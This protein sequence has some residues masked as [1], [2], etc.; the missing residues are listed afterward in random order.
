MTAPEAATVPTGGASDPAVR[1]VLCRADVYWFGIEAGRVRGLSAA[2]AAV[3]SLG[4]LL[5][6][7]LSGP[8]PSAGRRL[9]VAAAQGE[10]AFA[11]AE[12]V[13]QVEVPATAIHPLPV[14]LAARQCLPW[15]RALALCPDHAAAPIVILDFTRAD[16][17]QV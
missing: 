7:P 5:G 15:V 12:P 13:I 16:G 10:L 1:L 3:P 6:L 2:G 9:R 4:A 17:V 14:V 11:V 8:V